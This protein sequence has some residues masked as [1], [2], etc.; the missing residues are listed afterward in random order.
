MRCDGV[1]QLDIK[2]S[3]QPAAQ[4]SRATPP[5]LNA[6]PAVDFEYSDFQIS[7]VMYCAFPALLAAQK[8][9]YVRGVVM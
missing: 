3:S 5:N 1:C 7:Y 6:L 4:V 2:E 8:M 9:W